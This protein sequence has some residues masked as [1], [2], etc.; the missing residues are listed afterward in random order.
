M[1]DNDKI[2]VNLRAVRKAAG[3]SRD[4]LAAAIDVHRNTIVRLENGEQ[5]ATT[6]KLE[7]AYRLEQLLGCRIDHLGSIS[8]TVL[9]VDS[10]M[11]LPEAVAEIKR[12]MTAHAIGVRI[13]DRAYTAA[14]GT[15]I[16]LS[17]TVLA[18]NSVETLAALVR[19]ELEIENSLLVG[20][21]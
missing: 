7:R 13:N 8:P 20:P 3:L 18:D 11:A 5:P 6:L 16:N 19:H 4:D 14:W 9:P 1:I 12:R 17:D 2:A 15:V 21:F 10:K